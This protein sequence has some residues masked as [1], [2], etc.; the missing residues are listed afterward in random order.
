[1]D[2]NEIYALP[3][4][5]LVAALRDPATKGARGIFV[6][7]LKRGAHDCSDLVP[8][9]IECV[10]HGSFEEANHAVHILEGMDTIL[11]VTFMV[12]TTA[13]LRVARDATAAESWRHEA[14]DVC[15]DMF[16][17]NLPH[18]SAVPFDLDEQQA[19][20]LRA[21]I[22]EADRGEFVSLEDATALPVRAT[23]RSV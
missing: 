12:E 7:A 20:E 8:D 19:E 16:A 4:E 17:S 21:S 1:M 6:F 10:L 18:D 2:P 3:K 13:R 5:R 23:G 11:P 15:L 22:E 9:L 14:I